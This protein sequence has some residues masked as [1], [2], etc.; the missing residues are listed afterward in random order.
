[1]L[2]PIS[3]SQK[4]TLP[5]VSFSSLPNTFGHQKYMPANSPKIAPPNST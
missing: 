2:N 3:I 4:C 5:T 1:M